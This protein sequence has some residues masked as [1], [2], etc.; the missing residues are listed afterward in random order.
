MYWFHINIGL[1]NWDQPQMPLWGWRL[2]YRFPQWCRMLWI[3][4]GLEEAYDTIKKATKLIGSLACGW[5]TASLTSFAGTLPSWGTHTMTL[6][7]PYRALNRSQL[8]YGCE[9]YSSPTVLRMLDSVHT[10]LRICKI[11]KC[12]HLRSPCRLRVK[13]CHFH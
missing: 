5:E 10:T 9:A 7:R 1:E 2:L 4:F 11:W 13:N 8:G 12:F 6:L 3:S